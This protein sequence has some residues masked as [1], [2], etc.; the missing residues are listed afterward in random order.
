[1]IAA[2][3]RVEHGESL[4]VRSALQQRE[5]LTNDQARLKPLLYRLA[6]RVTIEVR[7]SA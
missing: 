7:R 4:V 1:M 5:L 2:D 6:F 3:S